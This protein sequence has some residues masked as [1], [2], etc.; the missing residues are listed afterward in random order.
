MVILDVA[1]VVVQVAL[2]VLSGLLFWQWMQERQRRRRRGVRISRRIEPLVR[3]TI[4]AAVVRDPAKLTKALAELVDDEKASKAVDI[5]LRV[6]VRVLWD[7]HRGEPNEPELRILA[8]DI[9]AVESWAQLTP[10]QVF[11]FLTETT[12]EVPYAMRTLP[13]EDTILMAFV[14]AGHLLSVHRSADD[15]WWDYLDRVERRIEAGHR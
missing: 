9:A 12:A 5:A 8:D 11:T 4:Y 1:E 7:A 3:N 2:W 13:P 6:V 14:V 10:E 15:R